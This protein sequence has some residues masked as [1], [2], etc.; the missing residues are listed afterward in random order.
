VIKGRS[1]S[2]AGLILFLA[3]VPGADGPHIDH[4]QIYIGHYAKKK[5]K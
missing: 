5:A 3:L 2:D 4:D 1:G